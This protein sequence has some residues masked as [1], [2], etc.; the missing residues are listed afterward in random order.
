MVRSI[1]NGLPVAQKDDLWR[2]V[3][4]PEVHRDLIGNGAV[5]DQVEVIKVELVRAEI[6]FTLQPEFSMGTNP[7]AGAVL[8][9]DHRLLVRGLP[10]LIQLLRLVQYFPILEDGFRFPDPI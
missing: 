1:K 9:N 4:Y 8:K 10:Q 7:T 6:P 5:G 3:G 2:L